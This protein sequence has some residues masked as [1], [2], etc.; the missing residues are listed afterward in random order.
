MLFYFFLIFMSA[1]F[2]VTNLK[3]LYLFCAEKLERGI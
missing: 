3:R 2:L 1:F